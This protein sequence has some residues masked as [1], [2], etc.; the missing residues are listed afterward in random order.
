MTGAVPE[1]TTFDVA[2]NGLAGCVSVD[3]S[4]VKEIRQS[5]DEFYVNVHTADFPAGAL[6]GQL[7]R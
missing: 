3:R 4:L 7:S 5:P 1:P 6:R 2:A